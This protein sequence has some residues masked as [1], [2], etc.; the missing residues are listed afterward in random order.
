MDVY[1][2]L[3][4]LPLGHRAI[5]HSLGLTGLKKRRMLDLGFVSG[6]IVEALLRSPSG[7]PKA[8][9]IKGTVIALREDDA[10]NIFINNQL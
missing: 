4:S 1:P 5:V 8:Y 6:S 3:L 9:L 7:D 10:K 2:S